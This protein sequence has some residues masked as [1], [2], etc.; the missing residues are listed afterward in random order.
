MMKIHSEVNEELTE[1]YP[2]STDYTVYIYIPK[3]DK[4]EVCITRDMF[5]NSYTCSDKKANPALVQ[6][7][8]AC[9]KE[10]VAKIYTQSYY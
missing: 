10:H 2:G 3:Q 6:I 9:V 7:A 1:F 5:H 8:V 4:R